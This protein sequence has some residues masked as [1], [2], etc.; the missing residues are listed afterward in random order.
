MTS[1]ESTCNIGKRFNISVNNIC[2]WKKTC[3]RKVG[4]GRKIINQDLEERV[5][6]FIIES[7]SQKKTLTRKIIQ[8]KAKEYSDSSSF[9]ASKGWFERFYNRNISI[10]KVKQ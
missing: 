6:E 3:E 10:F 7:I 5:K 1:K 8:Q 2:R 9:K 4:A